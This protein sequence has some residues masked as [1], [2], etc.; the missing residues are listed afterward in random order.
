MHLYKKK[1]TVQTIL[2]HY[3]PEYEL[4]HDLP[5][6]VLNAAQRLID[7]RTSALGGHKYYCTDCGKEEIVYNPCHHRICPQ[8]SHI[9]K[10]E[11]LKGQMNRMI[12]TNYYHIVFTIPSEYNDYWLTNKKIMTDILFDSVKETLIDMCLNEKLLGVI[13]GIIATLHTWGSALSLHPH[14]HCLITDGGLTKDG[15]WKS[16]R[17]GKTSRKGFLLPITEHGVMGVFRAKF[18]FKMIGSL[19]RDK[20]T[21]PFTDGDKSNSEVEALYNKLKAKKWNVAIRERYQHGNGVAKYLANYLKGGAI[22]NSRIKS[23]VDEKVTFTYKNSRKNR[24]EELMTLDVYEF[25]KRLLLHVPEKRQRL[26]RYYGLFSSSKKELLNKARKSFGQPAVMKT[27][28]LTIDIICKECGH[29]LKMLEK[30]EP[31]RKIEMMNYR[32]YKMLNEKQK[33]KKVI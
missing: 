16:G 29:K 23:C 2:T 20:L 3:F 5:L 22:G 12:A 13:P 28:R 7:C 14:I 9:A 6:Y 18:T 11:W 10:D 26:V 1:T 31:V 33:F 4:K 32:R 19:R 21:L 15:S 27:D 30:I 24:K 8:C 17:R 25:I